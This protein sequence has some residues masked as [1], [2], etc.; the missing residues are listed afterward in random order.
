MILSTPTQTGLKA[1]RDD[2]SRRV[3]SQRSET[4]FSKLKRTD[5]EISS[6]PIVTHGRK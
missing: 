6:R 2:Q 3:M 1:K 5:F 4:T